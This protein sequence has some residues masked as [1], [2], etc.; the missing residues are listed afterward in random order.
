LNDKTAESRV[1]IDRKPNS[2]NKCCCNENQT[3]PPVARYTRWSKDKHRFVPPICEY[4]LDAS[5]QLGK[6][7]KLF[8][9]DKQGA[10]L[11]NWYYFIFPLQN[12]PFLGPLVVNGNGRDVQ[13][14]AM[15]TSPRRR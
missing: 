13:I 2:Y 12:H 10:G 7:G 5:P 1:I 14:L 3:P 4:I 15:K 9:K 11:D 8:A 6:L